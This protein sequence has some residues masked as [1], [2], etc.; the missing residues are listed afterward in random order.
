MINRGRYHYPDTEIKGILK[1]AVV[2]TDTREQ[3]NDHILT[4]LDA[5]KV[6]HAPMTLSFGDYSVMLPAMPEAGISRDIY[7]DGEIIIERKRNLDELAGNF[8]TGRERFKDEMIRAGQAQKYLIIEQGGGYSAILNSQYR[9]RLS[10]KSF[11]ASLLSFQARYGL[12]VIFTGPDMSAE[13]IWGLLYYHV[14]AWL[15]G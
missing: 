13:I 9:A 14:R 6:S 2:L 5:L 4:A 7:F 15:A 12:N 11:F 8:T 10:A 3:Q 1:R